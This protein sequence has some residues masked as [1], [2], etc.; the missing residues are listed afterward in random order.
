MASCLPLRLQRLKFAV[1][2]APLAG[3]SQHRLPRLPAATRWS[4]S[5]PPATDSSVSP[6]GEAGPSSSTRPSPFLCTTPIFY[7]N[8]S[9]HVG[10]LHSDV[11]ADVLTRW[12]SLRHSGWSPAALAGKGKTQPLLST[13]TDEHG[14]KIQKVAEMSGEDPQALCDRISQRFRV[15]ADTA[16]VGYTDF[17]RTTEDRHKVA[18]HEIWVSRS[19]TRTKKFHPFNSFL[20]PLFAVASSRGCWPHLQRSSRRL[21]RRLRR[22]LLPSGSGPVRH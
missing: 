20:I 21:V 17:I 9:P 8:A 5:A 11:L 7:V 12:S 1:T 16:G 3:P 22:S 6:P 14:L 10:H 18:V 2:A 4:S 13:G 19:V 15:L